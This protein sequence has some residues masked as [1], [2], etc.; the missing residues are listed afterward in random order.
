MCLAVSDCAK[1]TLPI[2]STG[3]IVVVSNWLGLEQGSIHVSFQIII[4][5]TAIFAVIVKYPRKFTI[6]QTSLWIKITITFLPLASE[7][8]LFKD[9][10]ENLF[11][12]QFLIPVMFILGGI[13]FLLALPVLGC[14]SA[15]QLLKHY[16]DFS[17]DYLAPLAVGF[18]TAFIVSF[19]SMNIFLWVMDM[20]SLAAFGYYRI[21]FGS[22]LI[23]MLY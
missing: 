7:G 8:F 10:I 1:K 17:G 5:V 21:T 23:L 18:V 13:S 6:Q 3:H 9:Q 2:S 14:V 19:L 22:L 20:F 16:E 12:N 4:R 15:Y 11:S